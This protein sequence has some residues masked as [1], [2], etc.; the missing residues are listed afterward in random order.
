[1]VSCT[2]FISIEKNNVGMLNFMVRL[3]AS[4]KTKAVLPIDGREAITVRLDFSKPPVTLSNEGK[5]DGKLLNLSNR[6]RLVPEALNVAFN[7][8]LKD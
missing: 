6:F 3:L 7:M 4:D 8:S 1:M 2:S 5:P